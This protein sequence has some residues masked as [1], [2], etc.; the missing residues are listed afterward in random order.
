MQALVRAVAGAQHGGCQKYV[1]WPVED[2]G[3][4]HEATVRRI[5]AAFDGRVRDLVTDLVPG[6]ALPPRCST[7]SDQAGCLVPARAELDRG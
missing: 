7:A 6:I 5:I 1:D 4:Q 2:P 3:R